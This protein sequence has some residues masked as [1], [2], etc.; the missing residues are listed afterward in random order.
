MNDLSPE[1]LSSLRL[2]FCEEGLEGIDRWEALVLKLEQSPT[3]EGTTDVKKVLHNIKGSSRAVGF[4]RLSIIVHQLES[5]LMSRKMDKAFVDEMLLA[6][7]E[8]RAFL[9]QI[10]SQDGA[11]EEGDQ[12]LDR[13]YRLAKS[14]QP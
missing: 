2:Q 11:F 4:D 10:K 3:P 13:L 6:I 8:I 5:D 9:N 1:F 12:S 7:D 14:K